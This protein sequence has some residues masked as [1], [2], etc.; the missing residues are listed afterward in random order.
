MEHIYQVV[1]T[2]KDDA[3]GRVSPGGHKVAGRR[4]LQ[5]H[6]HGGEQC[7]PEG[8]TGANTHTK[9]SVTFV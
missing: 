7:M 5:R 4:A 9:S 1:D 2:S 6:L 3:T 8:I